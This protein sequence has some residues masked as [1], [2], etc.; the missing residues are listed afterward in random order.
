MP[1]ADQPTKSRVSS[2]KVPGGQAATPAADQSAGFDPDASELVNGATDF[3]DGPD[4]PPSPVLT[5]TQDQLDAAIARGIAQAQ[6]AA[7]AAASATPADIQATL[8]DQTEIDPD[9]ITAPT[10]S[11]QG[12][13]IPRNYGMPA[14]QV[15]HLARG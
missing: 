7:R 13:V 1:A 12:Y 8:P 4:V 5:L 6:A 2:V 15:A 3:D 11:K 10:L 14:A 9:E